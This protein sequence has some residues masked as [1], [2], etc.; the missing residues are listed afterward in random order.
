MPKT[1]RDKAIAGIK[2][3]LGDDVTEAQ[4]D[5]V[6]AAQQAV[7]E[8]EPVGTVMREEDSGKIAHRVNDNGVVQWRVTGPDGECY[9]DLQPT[10][11]WQVIYAVG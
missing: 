7:A 10:L 11:P 8:G 3:M 1:L 4:I 2:A 6:L 9:N 5:A